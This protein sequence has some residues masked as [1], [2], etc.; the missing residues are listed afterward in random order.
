MPYPFVHPTAQ[1][2]PVARIQED[3]I[4]GPGVQIGPEAEITIHVQIGSGTHI[5]GRV[6]IGAYVRIGK[7]VTLTG[8][9]QIHDD[10]VI[11]D[12]VSVGETLAATSA[13]DQGVILQGAHLEANAIVLG[14]L[15]VGDHARVRCET[16]LE[17]DLPTHAVA[18][19][20]PAALV[21]FVCECGQPY[22][23]KTGPGELLLCHCPA[24]QNNYR[25]SRPIF[26]RRLKFL[27]PNQQAGEPVP[28]WWQATLGI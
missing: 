16:R 13:L 27:L 2:D 6:K 5:S 1:V 19:G 8:P 9:L 4:A 14:L 23:F 26:D 12:G 21:E 10:V 25:L 17:G 3:L 11:E 18:A 28:S 22:H 24:C 20:Q 15:S 7:R